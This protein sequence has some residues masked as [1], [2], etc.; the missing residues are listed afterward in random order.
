MSCERT[1]LFGSC[2]I[3]NIVIS[4][5]VDLTII[6]ENKKQTPLLFMIPSFKEIHTFVKYNDK[7]KQKVI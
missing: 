7:L 4:P 5:M 6:G 3:M 2:F 1:T